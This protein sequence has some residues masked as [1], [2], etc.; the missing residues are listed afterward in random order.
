MLAF[1]GRGIKYKSWQ[2]MLQLYKTLIRPHLKYCV[3]FW[4]PHN[5]KDVQVL[6]RVETK[7]TRMLPGL[8]GV[9]YEER[10]NKLGLFSWRLRGDLIEGYKVERYR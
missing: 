9:G 2:V 3:Q 5:Q 4:S 1:V 8:K 6:E 10:L 7:F